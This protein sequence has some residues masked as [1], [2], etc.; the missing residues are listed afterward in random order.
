[1][2][3][4]SFSGLCYVTA[5]LFVKCGVHNLSIG[6]SQWTICGRNFASLCSAHPNHI[7]IYASLGSGFGSLF[8]ASLMVLA[9]SYEYDSLA[10][11]LVLCKTL[12]PQVNGG[13][14][15]SAL[16]GNHACR[17][18]VNKCFGCSIVR[19]DRQL[20]VCFTG[21][22]TKCHLIVFHL[23]H[24]VGHKQ[25]GTIQTRW[26]HIVGKHR[27]WH[28]YHHNCFNAVSCFGLLLCTIERTCYGQNECSYNKHEQAKAY[29]FA[30]FRPSRH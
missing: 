9:I 24:H 18:R 4:K 1:M 16:H 2:Q 5:H 30:P 21:K 25:F 15:I 11:V 8:G 17:Q 29:V 19:C 27:V 12:T 7:Y 28:V 14:N 23:V 22:Y 3:V 13:C 26:L 6:V 20:R 10:H